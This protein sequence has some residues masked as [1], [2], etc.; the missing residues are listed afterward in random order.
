MYG[1]R[2]HCKITWLWEKAITP[3]PQELSSPKLDSRKIQKYRFSLDSFDGLWWRR[4]EMAVVLFS[5]QI[6]FNFRMPKLRRCF[7]LFFSFFVAVLSRE[8]L[9]SN[10]ISTSGEKV[11]STSGR[12]VTPVCWYDLEKGPKELKV[13]YHLQILKFL[14]SIHSFALNSKAN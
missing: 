7:F 9:F 8:K 6:K 5:C 13:T 12:L 2:Y 14:I 11:I 1:W 4:H 3:C 10:I